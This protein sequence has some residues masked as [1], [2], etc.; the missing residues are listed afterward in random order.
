MSNDRKI[1]RFIVLSPYALGL[2]WGAS[3]AR[4]YAPL[5]VTLLQKMP[6]ILAVGAHLK[7]TI[8]LSI[9]NQAFI[10]QH[11]GDLETAEAMQAF[12]RVIADFLRLYEAQPIAIAHD[13]HP[14]YLSTKWAKE[15]ILDI[16]Y[17]ISADSVPNTQYPIPSIPV[18]HHHAHL[19]SVLAE[20]HIDGQALGVIWDGTGYGTDGTIWGGEFLLGDT[21]GYE[22][23]AHLRPFRLP[24]GDAAVKEPRRVALA[25]LWELFGEAALDRD[26]LAP[27]AAL[28][29]GERSLLG[30]MLRKGVNTPLTTSMGRLFDGVAALLDLHQTVSFEAEAAMAL[31]FVADG[32]EGG[33]YPLP[34]VELKIRDQRLKIKGE[35]HGQSLIINHQSLILD[36][37]PLISAILADLD[38]R[39]P[40]PTIAARFHNA[41]I[42]AIV[43]VA[44]RVGEPRVALSG[45][46][47]QNRLLTERATSSL[48]E[49]GFEVILHRQVPPNDGGVSL[50]QIAIAAKQ[51]AEY[52]A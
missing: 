1:Y 26:D 4:G 20:N 17:W 34:L 51:L 10:S 21:G 8:A 37:R 30:Q 40:I 19:A 29:P 16:G 50:G 45:G 18:Q 36:W 52:D 11:I 14:D 33:A 47:W 42:E 25:L 3:R 24:G 5:P 31:E 44:H 35:P 12:E 2:G 32:G 49:N 13:L 15:K 43:A 23:V 9:G 46:V 38:Q 27:I 7:N 39:V 22:R 6:V 48:R 41:L 28:S